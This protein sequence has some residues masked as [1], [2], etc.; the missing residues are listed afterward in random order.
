MASIALDSAELAR[1]LLGPDGPVMR[2]LLRRGR[3]VETLA[4]ELCPVDFGRLRSSITTQP[5]P[6]GYVLVGSNVEYAIYVHEN[7]TAR[8][9][10]GQCHYLTDAL[11]AAAD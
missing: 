3:N 8:H 6:E 1:V 10:V 5:V 2:E 4:K 11:V 7:C 9:R